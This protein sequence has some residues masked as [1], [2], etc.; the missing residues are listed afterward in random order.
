M[1]FGNY[2]LFI[3]YA[4][5][6][7]QLRTAG[8]IDFE[9]PSG[10]TRGSLPF[11]NISITIDGDTY[12]PR[13]RVPVLIRL[14]DT[15]AESSDSLR[16]AAD[17]GSRTSI[18]FSG[19][20]P[21]PKNCVSDFMRN[22]SN[23]KN[24]YDLMA[25]VK[26]ARPFLVKMGP[27]TPINGPINNKMGPLLLNA[28]INGPICA[29]D[30]DLYNTLS[31]SSSSLNDTMTSLGNDT[32]NYLINAY[33]DLFRVP[34]VDIFFGVVSILCFAIGVPANTVSLAFFLHKPDSDVE[35]VGSKKKTDYAALFYILIT[36]VDIITSLL[37]LPM[38]VSY[39]SHRQP[40]ILAHPFICNLWGVLWGFVARFSI[41]LVA[42]LS[43]TRTLNLLK[44]FYRIRPV[45][46]AVPVVLYALAMSLISIT[47]YI[48]EH[49]IP[50][51]EPVSDIQSDPDLMTSLGERVLVTKSGWPLNRG[52]IT[53][54]SYIGGNLPCY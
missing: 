30:T 26:V 27:L 12:R 9:W 32:G 23:K 36:I 39:L 46:V 42:C 8:F 4:C 21:F 47:P 5:Y 19:R 48:N 45:H 18:E 28:P 3:Y 20:T 33:V 41:F 38:G 52:Q 37:M 22:D 44:P 54:I 25:L 13:K 11:A 50:S 16:T 35:V 29:N 53:L 2:S 17:R 43:I 49:H 10:R 15:D 40:W 51:R 14:I 1:P 31:P 24:M 34:E 6:S 7:R